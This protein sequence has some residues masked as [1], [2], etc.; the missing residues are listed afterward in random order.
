MGTVEPATGRL[1]WLPPIGTAV[2]AWLA[3]GVGFHADESGSRAGAEQTVA[4]LL[5]ATPF[6][7]VA[8]AQVACALF[9]SLAQSGRQLAACVVSTSVGPALLVLRTTTWDGAAVRHQVVVAV[10]ALL[11]LV[12]AWISLGRHAGSPGRRGTP[13]G[14]LDQGRAEAGDVSEDPVVAQEEHRRG[15]A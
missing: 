8:L 6:A 4:G 3:Y 1:L 5:F 12:P 13:E 9:A 2:L 10:A 11:P 7:M 14:Q 15:G